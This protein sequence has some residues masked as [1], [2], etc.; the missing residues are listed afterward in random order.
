MWNYG[1]FPWKWS[2]FPTMS[3][4]MNKVSLENFLDKFEIGRLK[5]QKFRLGK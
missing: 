4:S 2:N 3:T 5:S 1:G